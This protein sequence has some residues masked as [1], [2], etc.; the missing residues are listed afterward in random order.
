MPTKSTRQLSAENAFLRE[1]VRYLEAAIQEVIDWPPPDY[2]RRTPQ[3]MPTEV[4][5]DRW[6]YER[7]VESY[8]AGL[9]SRLKQK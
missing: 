5:Y 4:V 7:L 9:S 6:A 3:G 2:P 1:R 8:R